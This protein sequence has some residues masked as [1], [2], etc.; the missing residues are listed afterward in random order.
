MKKV[1][2]GGLAL[3]TIVG[4]GC[5]GNGWGFTNSSPEGFGSL[6][7]YGDSAG[8]QAINDGLNGLIT[9]GKASPDM[10]TSYWNN[11]EKENTWK[12]QNIFKMKPLMKAPA[13]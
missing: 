1:M 11:R 2:I 13:K 9:N 10:P 12:L 7:I 6:H 4:T 5:S 3:L 8:L